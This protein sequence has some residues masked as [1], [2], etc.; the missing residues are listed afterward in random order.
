VTACPS[1]KFVNAA[2]VATRISLSLDA[3]TGNALTRLAEKRRMSRNRLVTEQVRAIASGQLADA[4]ICW[5]TYDRLGQ[6]V[7]Q[8]EELNFELLS[9]SDAKPMTSDANDEVIRLLA[10]AR[11]TA[12]HL[13]HRLALGQDATGDG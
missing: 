2:P 13:Q 7:E 4:Q 5:D 10:E 11:D 6:L 12:R 8:L 3:E 1:S 9:Q